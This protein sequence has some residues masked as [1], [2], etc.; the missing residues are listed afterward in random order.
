M[1]F[2][3]VEINSPEGRKQQTNTDLTSMPP[4]APSV[5]DKSFP[6]PSTFKVHT[7]PKTIPFKISIPQ[8]VQQQQQ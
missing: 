2:L 7:R 1:H 6:R 3:E 4:F 5:S 8:Q